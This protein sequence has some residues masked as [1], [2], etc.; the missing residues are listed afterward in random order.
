[1]SSLWQTE[2]GHLVWR[3][4]DVA[5]RVQYD[6]SWMQDTASMQGSYLPPPGNF[7][8]HSPFGGAHWFQPN[9]AD[10]NSD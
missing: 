7:A 8:S 2:A 10:R 1:M 3:W 6:P 5:E 9:P 4:S